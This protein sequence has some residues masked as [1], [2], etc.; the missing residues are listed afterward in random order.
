MESNQKL[1]QAAGT[2]GGMTIIS[3]ILGFARDL[4]IAMQFGAT[5]AADAF[6][7]AF[8][9]PNV[10][11]KVL[12]EG[13]ISAAFIP[14]FTETRNQKGEEDAWVMTANLFNILLAVLITSS[15]ALAIFA[16]YIIII[17]APGFIP[18]PE[19]FNLTVL[20]TQ[21]MA[22]Y[23]LF[24]GLAVFCMGILNSY[25]MFA[26]PAITPAILNICMITGALIISPKL[27]QPILGLAIGVVFGGILQFIIQV[28]AILKCGF[29]FIPSINWKNPEALKVC[30]LMIPAIFGLAVY[31]LNMLVDTLLASLLPEGSISYLYY[32]NRLVQLPLGV[33]GVA[34]GIAI[35]PMLSRQVVKK[36]FSD[37]IKTIS[38]GTRLI[39]FITIPATIGLI[40]LRFPIINTLWERG[41][42]N[43]ITTEGTAIALLYYSAG[44]CAFCG[45]KIIVPAFYSLQDT[46]TPVK[47]GIYSMVLNIILN[48]ILMGPLKHGG[49]ALATSI[50]A[51]FNV[52]LLIYFLRKRMGLMGGRKI[53]SSV[54]KLFF[55][56]GI[57]GITVYY[58]N[59]NFFN[60]NSP[61]IIKLLTLSANI[62]IGLL[63]YVSLSRIIQNQ[64]LSF[65]IGLIRNRK[66]KSN[67]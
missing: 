41:E 21:W 43:R 20:L 62:S 52:T 1:G 42:F 34:L 57:M 44:L 5:F 59:I 46:K 7:V 61:L 56:S 17:F 23:F 8:R 55:V 54:I 16:P 32:G 29:K 2:V 60:P 30:R 63:V 26:L 35:L 33:F 40:I 64:E 15:L 36:D 22:P 47:I 13:A 65:L 18:I 37:M 24:I 66:K 51:L 3:R 10:Q 58:F 9:I 28:P 45:L 31:E 48:L 4:V 12:S 25:N 6:F 14:V 53:L 38:F 50:A 27:D 39:L 19:K 67:I 11:R 49:L